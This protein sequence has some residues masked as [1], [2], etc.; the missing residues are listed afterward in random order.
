MLIRIEPLGSTTRL[1]F[2]VFQLEDLGFV[3]DSFEL[4]GQLPE[5]PPDRKYGKFWFTKFGWTTVGKNICRKLEMAGFKYRLLISETDDHNI[6][7]RDRYQVSVEG[8]KQC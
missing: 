2:A 8:D 1:S 7:Y 5:P 4:W 6:V 3:E